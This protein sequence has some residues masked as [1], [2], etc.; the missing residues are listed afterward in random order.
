M[1]VGA[2]RDRARART[3]CGWIATSPKRSLITGITGQDGRSLAGLVRM[4]VRSDLE[5]TRRLVE[6]L[7]TNGGKDSEKHEG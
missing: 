4:M 1:G 5:N 7:G 6:G 3:G 2:P